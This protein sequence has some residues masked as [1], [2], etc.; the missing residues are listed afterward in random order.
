MNM[1]RWKHFE[2]S[3][4][5][6]RCCGENRTDPALID[7][8]DA[9]RGFA[10]MPFVVNSGYRCP[11]HTAAVGS[12]ADNHPSGQAADIKCTDG[13]TRMRLIEALIKAGFRRIGFHR[14]FIH[15]DRMDQS[16][17]KVRSFWPY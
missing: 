11:K 10:G 1:S 15:V 9:A 14:L 16:Q 8:L 12:T 6:C 5:A 7:M 13:P 4:F 17:N 2:Y 3:E